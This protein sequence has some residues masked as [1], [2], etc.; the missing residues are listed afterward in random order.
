M[1]IATRFPVHP[2]TTAC[3]VSLLLLAAAPA[4]ALTPP[5]DGSTSAP[6]SSP[7]PTAASAVAPAAAPVVASTAA[8]TAAGADQGGYTP[9]SGQAGKDVVW[10]PTP[11][12]LVDS[13]LDSAGLT[14]DDYVIDLG[15]G[16][17][18]TVI[19]AARRGARARGIEY[20]GDMVALARRNAAEAGL[21]N[22]VVFDQGDIF[23]SDFSEAT[24]LTLFLLP[25]L[26]LRLRPT[27]LDMKPGTRVVSNSFDMGDWTPDAHIDG[28]PGCKSWCRAYKWIVPAKVSGDWRFGDGRL[29]LEQ[30]YQM[31]SGTL[32]E[33]GGTAVI[34]DAKMD[35]VKIRFVAGGRSYEGQANGK[36]MSGAVDGKAWSATRLR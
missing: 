21:G 15:S 31:L 6:A 26:N 13:M 19:T 2:L 30:H 27:I 17:G 28:G 18:R 14:R 10:V 8:A 7:L 36:V 24:V 5:T 23:E 29:H 9:Y 16:D 22:E 12:A 4:R 1:T 34:S 25:Q 20:N 33:G 35:G 3:A 11:Q 32:T